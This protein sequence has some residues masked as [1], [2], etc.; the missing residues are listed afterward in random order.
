ME[1][2]VAE[3]VVQTHRNDKPSREEGQIVYTIIGDEPSLEGGQVARGSHGD[4][5][6]LEGGPH[7]ERELL[8]R[9]EKQRKIQVRNAE[10]NPILL[11]QT[12]PQ[13]RRRKL[14]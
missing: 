14:G 1:C 2:S 4:E 9:V 8:I 11:V 13:I 7:G 10:R 3:T 6:S 5:P 12:K